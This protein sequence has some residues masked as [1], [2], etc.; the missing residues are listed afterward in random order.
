MGSRNVRF[1]TQDLRCLCGPLRLCVSA[2]NAVAV[3]VIVAVRATVAER[4]RGLRASV[5]PW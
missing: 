4:R 3:S 1:E 2:V 5:P